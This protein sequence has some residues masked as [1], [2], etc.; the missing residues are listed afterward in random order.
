MNLLQ[1]KLTEKLPLQ[2]ITTAK[3]DMLKLSFVIKTPG[4]YPKDVCFETL[5][6]NVITFLGDTK[7][8]TELEVKFDL[9]SRKWEKDG[10]VQFFTSAI[11]FGVEKKVAPES[12]EIPSTP[13]YPATASADADDLPF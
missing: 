8:G 3:G 2:T 1:G 6:Q 5:N 10:R 4:Q 7:I 9:Q 13:S 11:A 12:M